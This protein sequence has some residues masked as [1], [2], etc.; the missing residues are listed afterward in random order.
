MII[1]VLS[2]THEDKMKALQYIV[3]KE[4]L[5]RGVE[6]IIHCGDIIPEH[7]DAALFGNLPV[8]CALTDEQESDCAEGKA[9]T[10]CPGAEPPGWRFTRPGKRI[11]QI[12]KISAYVGHK[13]SYDYWKASKG[14]IYT[15][16]YEIRKDHNNVRYLFAGHMHHQTLIESPLISFINPGATEGAF[17]D[18]GGYEFAIVDTETGEIIFSRIKYPMPIKKPLKLGVISD[19][20]DVS[21]MNPSFWGKL[22]EK[23]RKAEVTHV[24]HCGNISADDVGLK[25]LSDFQVFYYLRPEQERKPVQPD[26][27]VLIPVD[28]PI[29]EINGYRFL[30]DLTL[31]RKL[32]GKSEAET[33]SITSGILKANPETNFILTGFTQNAFLDEMQNIVVINPGDIKNDQDYTIIDLPRYE[34]TFG[35]IQKEP[36]PSLD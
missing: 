10:L 35:R 25:E 27:W 11:V 6:L 24:I 29:V 1:G 36:L 31:S 12:G 20:F 28:P 2:D 9:D 15:K 3:R 18:A 8:I 26:N 32:L 13:L 19:S 21:E 22:A 5:P 23:F 17:G 16:M 7:V 33:Y 34:I 30:V 4:F 14:E